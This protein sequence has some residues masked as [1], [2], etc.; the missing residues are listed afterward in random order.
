MR[1]LQRRRDA[2]NGSLNSTPDSGI[3]PDSGIPAS[4][5]EV[6]SSQVR[7]GLLS[8]VVRQLESILKDI[9]PEEDGVSVTFS[10]NCALH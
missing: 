3:N 7:V 5:E 1:E 2:I 4:P 10:A 9:F 8:S 6:H